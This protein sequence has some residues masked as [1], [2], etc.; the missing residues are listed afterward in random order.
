MRLVR[1]AVPSGT[2]VHGDWNCGASRLDATRVGRDVAGLD[3]MLEQPC[4][5]LDECAAVRAATGLWR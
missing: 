1:A 3:I 2:L 5:T 4:A